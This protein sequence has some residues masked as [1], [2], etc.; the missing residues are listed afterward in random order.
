MNALVR[1][2]KRDSSFGPPSKYAGS[3][4]DDAPNATALML[5]SRTWSDRRHPFRLRGPNDTSI[6]PVVCV[7]CVCLDDGESPRFSG[8]EFFAA[9]GLPVMRWLQMTPVTYVAPY[10]T[11]V[12]VSVVCRS[13][14]S[15]SFSEIVPVDEADAG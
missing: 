13:G 7:G 8:T 5:M 14:A 2:Y 12:R 11:C 9:S 1:E 10:G 6:T 3:L 15:F 4:L